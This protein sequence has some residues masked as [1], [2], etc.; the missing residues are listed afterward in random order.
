MLGIQVLE[1]G[2]T[3]VITPAAR[4]L[5]KELRVDIVRGQGTSRSTDPLADNNWSTA[6]HPARLLVAGTPSWMVAIA[7]QLCTKQV[8]VCDMAIDDS[9]VLRSIAD[10][11]RAGH[12]AGLAI[13][14][15]PHALCWQAARDDRMRPAVVTAWHELSGILLEV[16]ANVLILS[17]KTWNVASTCNSARRFYQHLQKQS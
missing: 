14:N 3:T 15:S 8:S 6:T 2:K 10:G 11:L 7:R 13:V 4:D 12:Q 1:I 9:S 17:T 16:P 5:C